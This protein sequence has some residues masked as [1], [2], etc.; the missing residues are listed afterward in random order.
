MTCKDTSPLISESMDGHISFGKRLRLKIHLTICK[1]CQCYKNQLEIIKNLAKKIGSED[2][3][4]K[5]NQTLR[6]E[7]KEKI[8]QSLNNI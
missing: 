3:S 5:K 6:P 4:S 7:V 2:F 8:K 1:A